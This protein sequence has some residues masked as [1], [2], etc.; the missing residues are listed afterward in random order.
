M[1]AKI[2]PLSPVDK[3][4]KGKKNT[5]IRKTSKTYNGVGH[6]AVKGDR[7]NTKIK[8]AKLERKNK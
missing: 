4:K 8:Y 3:Q 5:Q 7:N 6:G 2:T 1:L